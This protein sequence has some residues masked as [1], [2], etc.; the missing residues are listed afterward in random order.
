MFDTHCHLYS[1]PLNLDLDRIIFKTKE[2]GVNYLVVPGVDYKT[3]QKS[4]E[5]SNCYENVYAAVGIH[6]TELIKEEDIEKEIFKIEE[7][8]HK[9]KVVAVGE[10]G[11][12]YYHKVNL[13]SVQKVLLQKQ[14]RLAI[15]Y[16]KTVIIHS[17]HSTE[18]IIKVLI[19]L[20]LENF[21]HSLVF[22]C[23]EP[24][25]EILNLSIKNN[26]FIGIDGDITF[27]KNKQDFIKNVPLEN[28][29]LETDSPLLAPTDDGVKDR[30][31]INYPYYLP[32]IAKKVSDIKNIS[33]ERVVSTTTANALLLFGVSS[34]YNK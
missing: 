15:K 34:G 20:G 22:H 3:S 31:K 24:V 29:V 5:I 18:D 28:L 2:S 17:R 13:E 23:A 30:N 27:D 8:I 32:Q 1:D 10:I 19:E 9:D 7:L 12:D 25:N 33:L 14:L 26:Y 6:P 16:N 4:I 11:L 21:E